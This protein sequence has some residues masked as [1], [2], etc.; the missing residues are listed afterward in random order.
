MS[1]K[2]QQE[3]SAKVCETVSTRKK[4]LQSLVILLC[5]EGRQSIFEALYLQYDQVLKANIRMSHL[6]KATL[7]LL[8][9][10]SNK[11]GTFSFSEPFSLHLT[12]QILRSV[13][14]F[15]VFL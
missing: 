15:I 13:G 3:C 6:S 5:F 4:F 12:I 9:S 14:Q 1:F 8:L 7:R 2:L 10:I 11:S